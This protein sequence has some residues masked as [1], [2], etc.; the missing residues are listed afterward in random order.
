MPITVTVKMNDEK[1]A[2]L[3]QVMA[4]R[5]NAGINKTPQWPDM[6][7]DELEAMAD[8]NLCEFETIN[9]SYSAG[10]SLTADDAWANAAD[11]ANFAAMIA[12]NITAKPHGHAK[13]E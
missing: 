9:V 1:T 5:L 7:I 6:D 8:M 13:Q 2:R 11:V 10:G 3:I 12:D 4:Q